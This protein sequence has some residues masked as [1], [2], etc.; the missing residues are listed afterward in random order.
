MV[1]VVGGT[2]LIG[3]ATV[4]RLRAE[5]AT[6]VPASRH[7]SEGIVMDARDD[8]SVH[9]G[10]ARVLAEHG[11]LDAVVV[12]AAPSA[13][14]LDPER[15]SDPAQVRDAFDAKALAFLRVAG[16]VLPGM[17]AAGFGRIV[18][19]SG[20][21]AFS[22]GNITGSVRNAALVIIAK[23]LADEVAGSGVTVNTVNPGIVTPA[24]DPQVAIGKSG[25]STPFEVADVITFL[26]S[27]RSSGVSGEAIAVGHRMRGFSGL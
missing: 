9:G 13:R 23:N 1:L 10:V 17:R 3:S 18:G 19:V 14:T 15:N 6:V 24:P 21:N 7:V 2:G 27:P 8:A 5:G 20:Q 4:E 12:A 11:R 16:A 26:A 22:T 25:Q